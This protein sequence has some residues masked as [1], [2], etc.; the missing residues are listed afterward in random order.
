MN[1]KYNQTYND[2]Y[3]G[4]YIGQDLEYKYK[5]EL[6]EYLYINLDLYNIRYCIMKTTEHAQQLKQQP[7]HITPHFH[8]YNYFLVFKKLSDNITR[9]YL[10]FRMDLKFTI[11]DINPNNIKIYRLNTVNYNIDDYDNTIIDGKLVYKKEQKIFLINDIFYFGGQ[12]Y[13]SM[14]I[15][16]KFNI[17][18]PYIQ[19]INKILN[20]IFDTKLIRIYKNSEMNDLVYNKI[21]NSDF[22]INGLVFIPHRTGKILIY[23]N[24]TE[25]ENIKNNPNLDLVSSITNV[26]F[27]NNTKLNK[28]TLLLQ[29][30]QIIDVYEVFTLDKIYRFGICCIPNI[31]LSHKLRN[32]FKNSDHLITECEFNNKFL[33]WMPII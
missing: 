33:K 29:K 15:L 23:I 19:Q 18:D 11:N 3:N 6:I 13:L 4:N 2:Q 26:K 22:K 30:T 10:I 14:K 8:G 31:D 20:Y 21:K 25:F 32:H 17:I 27:S 5:K 28:Q 9:A 7:Y 24:D 12:K 16:D 1:Y